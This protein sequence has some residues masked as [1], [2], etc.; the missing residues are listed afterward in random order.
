MPDRSMC[1]VSS[2]YRLNGP[3]RAAALVG[4]VVS[5]DAACR[6]P[7]MGCVR[8]GDSFPPDVPACRLKG[9]AITLATVSERREVCMSHERSKGN[10]RE[11]RHPFRL[12]WLSRPFGRQ[13]AGAPR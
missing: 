12:V 3:E 11:R 1:L 6:S 4:L 7:A 10:A 13:D 5:A 9:G 2:V 8:S